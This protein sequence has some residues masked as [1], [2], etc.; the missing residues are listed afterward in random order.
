MA[1]PRLNQS[2]GARSTA[3]SAR[4][5]GPGASASRATWAVPCSVRTSHQDPSKAPSRRKTAGGARRRQWASSA[6]RGDGAASAAPARNVRDGSCSRQRTSMPSAASCRRGGLRFPKLDAKKSGGPD[7]SAG[8]PAP[9][10][11]APRFRRRSEARGSVDEGKRTEE[12]RP[13]FSLFLCFTFSLFHFFLSPVFLSFPPC[14]R[15]LALNLASGPWSRA[16]GPGRGAPGP[17]EGSARSAPVP[18]DA[19][20]RSGGILELWPARS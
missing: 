13:F 2:S 10:N 7:M 15:V 19:R 17:E 18:Q 20:E 6:A 3:S 12:R 16:S 9:P 5:S 11:R 14:A 8:T 1:R 4:P